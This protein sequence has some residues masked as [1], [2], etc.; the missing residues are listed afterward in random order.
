[1]I[2]LESAS[3]H[4]GERFKL[5]RMR[6]VVLPP[7]IEGSLARLNIGVIE[8]ALLMRPQWRSFKVILL[9]SYRLA[10]NK[11]GLR[12]NYLSPLIYW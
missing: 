12:R 9:V 8:L 7:I 3:K 1:M 6:D 2:D 11:K 10:K 4:L 5:G